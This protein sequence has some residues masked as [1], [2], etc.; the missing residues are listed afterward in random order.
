MDGSLVAQKLSGHVVADVVRNVAGQLVRG[1]GGSE[2]RA[3]HSRDLLAFL[4]ILFERSQAHFTF[5][6]LERADIKA[7]TALFV[8]LIQAMKLGADLPQDE[9]GAERIETYVDLS[10]SKIGGIIVAAPTKIF[11]TNQVGGHANQHP[12]LEGFFVPLEIGVA[13]QQKLNQ[14]FTGPKWS[15]WCKSGIDEETANFIE[16]VFMRGDVFTVDRNAML[17][18]CEA[19]VYISLL[20][21]AA[22]SQDALICPVKSGHGIL[23]WNNSD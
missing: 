17:V 14:Y 23:T 15:G 21:A 4:D 22:N 11:Y 8:G 18:S 3:K 10:C 7:A 9:W 1:D 20:D 19:W 12:S 5:Q 13:E 16:S 6:E 2:A